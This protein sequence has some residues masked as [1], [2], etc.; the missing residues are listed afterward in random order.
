MSKKVTQ[1]PMTKEAAARIHRAEAKANDG[2]VNKNSF[3][4]RA[5]S[6]ADKK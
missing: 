2:G 1:K 3:T 6:V 5:Q 4:S